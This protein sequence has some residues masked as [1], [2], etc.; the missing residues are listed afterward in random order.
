L[1]DKLLRAYVTR[2]GDETVDFPEELEMKKPLRPATKPR[3]APKGSQ[4][5]AALP[6]RSGEAFS[7][8]SAEAAE[9]FEGG[10]APDIDPE[11]RLGINPGVRMEFG[12]TV[13]KDAS[14]KTI[15][16]RLTYDANGGTNSTVLRI[17]GKDHALGDPAGTWVEKPSK[18]GHGF[19]AAW[20]IGGIE[21]RQLLELTPGKQPVEVARGVQKRLLDTCLIRYEL[22]N[23]DTQPHKVELRLQ[24]DT[25][26]GNNDGVPF[27][28]PGLPGVVNTFKD[29][30]NAAEVPDFIQALE[31][32]DLQNPGTVAHLTLKM[33]GPFEAPARVSLTAWPG[34]AYVWDV[35][36]RDMKDDSAVVMYWTSDRA[37]PPGGTRKVGFAYGL[38]S[39][40]SSEQGDLRL[41]V[42]GQFQVGKP[43][44]VLAYVKRPQA[45]QTL[46][47]KLPAELERTE[48]KEVETVA[49][50]KAGTNDTSTVTWRIR[51]TKPGR[52]TVAVASSNGLE[53]SQAILIEPGAQTST[54]DSGAG[55]ADH[56]NI[57]GPWRIVSVELRGQSLTEKLKNHKVVF[58]KDRMT[59]KDGDKD[60]GEFN[61]KLDSTKK[62][63]W[64][65]LD[66]KGRGKIARGIYDLDGD[67]LKICHPDPEKDRS[68]AFTSIPDSI[69]FVLKRDRPS[70]NGLVEV[71]LIKSLA[72][73]EA[74]ARLTEKGLKVKFE[75]SPDSPP[76]KEKQFTVVSQH[77]AAGSKVDPGTEVTATIFPAFTSAGTFA[78]AVAGARE[79]GKELILTATVTSPDPKQTLTL[80]PPEG[81]TPLEGDLTRLVPASATSEPSKVEWK[82]KAAQAGEHRLVV[83]SSTGE[84][85]SEL[86]T[87]AG[88]TPPTKKTDFTVLDAQRALKMAVRVLPADLGYDLDGDG[89][90]TSSD[91]VLIMRRAL[92][93]K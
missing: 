84:E 72:A 41:T 30:K 92:D 83:L 87:I 28:V 48:G 37:L 63:R 32:G 57:Q 12:V 88:G 26:I 43:I 59:F 55:G 42:D 19:K 21:V 46:K 20:S 18:V 50:A 54:S 11:P 61:Y 5:E 44:S 17:D 25:L 91:A 13:A 7:L 89:R 16:K 51:A 6:G 23:K 69:L 35:P 75:G 29:F 71:P 73:A 65:D 52:F 34:R 33:G 38:G 56:D 27:A 39:V 80:K 82:L 47:L 1:D 8:V 93:A 2:D 49:A 10:D 4:E 62:P 76:T 81:L 31:R 68:T 40:S 60:D 66:L 70:K 85:K 53:Q 22:H 77:P 67:N 36:T 14:G 58:T 86:V 74:K 15:N 24:L 79:T 90:V 78:L 45:E 9:G 64:I 3:P